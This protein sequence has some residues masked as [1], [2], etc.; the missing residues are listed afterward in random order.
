L[1]GFGGRGTI[2][3][4]RTLRE[5]EVETRPGLRLPKR[6]G[7]DRREGPLADRLERIRWPRWYELDT[8]LRGERGVRTRLGRT[9]P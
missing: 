4:E 2:V 1:K 7:L 5:P 9:P 6:E 3:R 8:L